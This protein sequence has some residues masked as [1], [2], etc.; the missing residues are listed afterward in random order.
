VDPADASNVDSD[1][2]SG[3]RSRLQQGLQEQAY[4][5]G[6]KSAKDLTIIDTYGP[7]GNNQRAGKKV[8]P[9]GKKA[10]GPFSNSSQV[11]VCLYLLYE[12]VLIGSQNPALSFLKARQP[13]PF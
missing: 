4:N 11:F 1:R 8:G 5:L 3:R 9:A 7:G 12:V 6:L 2:E 10:E 13:R